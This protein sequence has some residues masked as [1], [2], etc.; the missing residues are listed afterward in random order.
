MRSSHLFRIFQEEEE[1]ER[2]DV[3]SVT[4]RLLVQ[5]TVSGE[6]E[7]HFRFKIHGGDLNCDIYLEE[8]SPLCS[9]KPFRLRLNASGR[10]IDLKNNTTASSYENITTLAINGSVTAY[11][12]SSNENRTEEFIKLLE[13]EIKE[14]PGAGIAIRWAVRAAG[15][16]KTKL[17]LEGMPAPAK[18]IRRNDR[19]ILDT[20]PGILI[21]SWPLGGPMASTGL[22]GPIPVIFSIN[23]EETKAKL[24]QDPSALKTGGSME[25]DKASRCS[26]CERY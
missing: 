12:G 11:V 15:A 22:S 8:I 13:Q 9:L 20:T 7:D 2:E 25:E 21:K 19:L 24:D 5:T 4:S 23:P 16:L 26:W 3:T 14:H 1:E 17:V 6:A 18:T 10:L